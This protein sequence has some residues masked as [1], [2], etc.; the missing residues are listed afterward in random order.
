MLSRSCFGGALGVSNSGGVVVS[1]QRILSCTRFARNFDIRSP[2]PSPPITFPLSPVVWGLV[3]RRGR[4]LIAR[5]GLIVGRRRS[6]RTI[7]LVGLG[8]ST[9]AQCSYAEAREQYSAFQQGHHA[10][11][12][13]SLDVQTAELSL[14]FQSDAIL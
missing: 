2:N 3:G 11:D 8:V 9:H 12:F 6:G 13:M 4:L 14:Q 1:L 5:R 10:I 7:H